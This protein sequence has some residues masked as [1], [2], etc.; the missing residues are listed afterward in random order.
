MT[1]VV[2]LISVNRSDFI[3]DVPYQQYDYCITVLPS[4]VGE[5]DRFLVFDIDFKLRNRRVRRAL[6]DDRWLFKWPFKSR[7]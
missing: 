4:G 6:G 1:S 7:R 2:S 3:A 5:I